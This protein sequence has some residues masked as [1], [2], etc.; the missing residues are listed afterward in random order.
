MSALHSRAANSTSVSSTVCNSN[1]ER[2]MTLRTS[3]VAVCCCSDSRSSLSNRVFSMAMTAWAAKF[4][5]KRDLLV[6]EGTNLLADKSRC[7]PANLPSLSIG[8]STWERAMPPSSGGIGGY[9]LVADSAVLW[10][11]WSCTQQTVPSVTRPG[12]K[13]R[14]ARPHEVGVSYWRIRQGSRF[15]PFSSVKIKRAKLGLADARSVCQH[16][17]EHRLQLAGRRTDDAQNVG[18]GRLLLQ[19][20]AAAR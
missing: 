15:E 17:L 1:A 18:G 2:L 6:G 9:R 12:R 19:R 4:C 7:A 10:T 16:G 11:I 8:T 14:S 3:A 5:S 20:F 13:S